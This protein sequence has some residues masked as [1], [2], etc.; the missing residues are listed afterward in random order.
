M[1]ETEK[2]M[3]TQDDPKD[4]NTYAY[5]N[6]FY[7]GGA[8]NAADTMFQSGS[9]AGSTAG[10]TGNAG[11]TGNSTGAGAT[12]TTSD[13]SGAAGYSYMNYTPP[14]PDPT[15][16]QHDLKKAAKKEKKAAKKAE[17]KARH[18]AN[19]TIRKRILTIIGILVVAAVAI[20][21]YNGVEYAIVT[22]ED[23]Y[24]D[25]DDTTT[26]TAK[27]EDA[28]EKTTSTSNK[29]SDDSWIA[30][31]GGGDAM[32]VADIVDKVSPSIVGVKASLE[33][34]SSNDNYYSDFFGSFFGYGGSSEPTTSYATS[35]G[36]GIIMSD[37]GYILTNA[38]IIYDSEYGYGEATA[39]QI[40]MADGETIYDADIV[41]YDVDAD[42][43]ILKISAEG[44]TPAEFGDSDE[45]RVGDM[46]VAIGNP[47]SMNFDYQN[48]VTCGIISGLDREITVNDN[49]MRLIQTDAA[50]NSGN[51]GGA[52]INSAGQVIGITS[53]KLEVS[54][55]GE[56]VEGMSF[57]IPITSAKTI[58]D[59]LMNF[60]YVTGRP[61]LGI[62]CQ[63]VSSS[64]AQAYNMPMGAYIISLTEGGPCEE[65]GL[66]VGD[67]ITAIQGIEVTT[68][69]ELNEVKNEYSA[70]DT[71]TLTVVR[72][73]QELEFDVVLAEMTETVEEAETEPA[74]TTTTTAADEAVS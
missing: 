8:E 56:T 54:Y 11:S 20:A 39:V 70:G 33:S 59:D 67:I 41:A 13:P 16:S 50:L 62:T 69:D 47:I 15:P 31:A 35:V 26:T 42:I 6:G 40:Q 34:V 10:N 51:S 2:T 37:D 36:T 74:E 29:T 25:D 9:G 32:S 28:S 58:V 19:H 38:H 72:A 18:K 63:D 53:A 60:G 65:A 30:L 12:A 5:Q 27:D 7:R 68:T 48:T 55:S 22:L 45:C 49:K 46:V 57:A 66:Q 14:Q 17:K 4:N 64:V 24:G 23:K 52:L 3:G 21:A 43:A 61:Q 73:G 1:D 71:V 44:L